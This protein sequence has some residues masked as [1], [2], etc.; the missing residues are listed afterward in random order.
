VQILEEVV[1]SLQDR[2]IALLE[3]IRSFAT[4]RYHLNSGID[5]L[6]ILNLSDRC[7]DDIGV[8]TAAETPVGRNHDHTN[9]LRF[10][11]CQQGMQ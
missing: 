9:L 6:Q 10:P 5:L 1:V 3:I 2:V 4:D 7:F 8:E 11:H